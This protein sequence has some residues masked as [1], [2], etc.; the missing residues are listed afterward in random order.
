MS[1][2]LL[3]AAGPLKP[4]IRL[5]QAV[6]LFE[7]DLSP[8][9][10]RTF[11]SRRDNSLKSPPDI[12]DVMHLTAE[13]DRHRLGSGPCLGPRL[14]NMLQAIQQFAALGDIVIGGAQN[15]IASGV[16]TLVRVTLLVR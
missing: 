2:A 4:E 9:Q 8:E 6:S 12:Q 15:I 11:R 7:A 10:K 1:S 14:T 13:I 5:A 16:W 3:R